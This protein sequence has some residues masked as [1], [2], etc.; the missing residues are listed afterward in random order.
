[1]HDDPVCAALLPDGGV[2]PSHFR[3]FPVFFVDGAVKGIA[4]P[5]DV[6]AARHLQ[7]VVGHDIGARR[8]REDL[9]DA[10]LILLPAVVLERCQIEEHSIGFLRVHGRGLIRIERAPRLPVML[11]HRFEFGVIRLIRRGYSRGE[12]LQYGKY[13][14]ELSHGGLSFGRCY[15]FGQGWRIPPTDSA[16]YGA[17]L[18]L[19]SN[20]YQAG[21][22]RPDT[23]RSARR[24]T[25]SRISL[26]G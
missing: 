5:G 1:M 9:L 24:I 23:I 10:G 7:V 11:D 2:P 22:R 18:R 12:G 16:L 8:A 19:D 26:R 13:R 17:G 4:G 3:V 21:S 14:Y 15:P 20:S 25:G 6:S